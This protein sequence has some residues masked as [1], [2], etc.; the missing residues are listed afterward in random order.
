MLLMYVFCHYV[1][2]V[3]A[4]MLIRG[5]VIRGSNITVVKFLLRDSLS[6]IIFCMWSISGGERDLGG[7]LW[8]RSIKKAGLGTLRDQYEEEAVIK[9]GLSSFLAFFS[10][11]AYKFFIVMACFVSFKLKLANNYQMINR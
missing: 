6:T 4:L 7:G 5:L 8:K 2:I 3:G 9:V 1:E 11:D 10:R